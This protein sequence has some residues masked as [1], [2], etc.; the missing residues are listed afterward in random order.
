MPWFIVSVSTKAH[1]TRSP[2]LVNWVFAVSTSITYHLLHHGDCRFRLIIS[3]TICRSA[4]ST[5]TRQRPSIL[6]RRFR[7][8]KPR[9][10]PRQAP[11]RSW[12]QCLNQLVYCNHN[13]RLCELLSAENGVFFFLLRWLTYQ[14]APE[15]TSVYDC[16]FPLQSL[17][18]RFIK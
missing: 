2:I 12:L 4:F 9:I 18:H 7:Q 8:P 1:D 16:W 10:S 13:C 17:S 6:R 3:N 15:P 5:S 14:C 11:G